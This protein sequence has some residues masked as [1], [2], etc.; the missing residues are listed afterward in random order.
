VTNGKNDLIKLKQVKAFLHYTFNFTPLDDEINGKHK[1][2]DI[3]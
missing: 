1:D 3:F 2:S